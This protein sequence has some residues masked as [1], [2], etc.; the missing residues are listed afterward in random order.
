MQ[1][2]RP[3]VF[4]KQPLMH[5]Q[6]AMAAMLRVWVCSGCW[7]QLCFTPATRQHSQQPRIM[8]LLLTG[9]LQAQ[10]QREAL[11]HQTSMRLLRRRTSDAADKLDAGDYEDLAALA[12]RLATQQEE[13]ERL[14]GQLNAANTKRAE[15]AKVGWLSLLLG[16]RAIGVAPAAKVV[17]SRPVWVVL[18]PMYTK[19]RRL[20]CRPRL[21]ASG[22][23]DSSC[24][25]GAKP[26]PHWSTH[27]LLDHIRH[28]Q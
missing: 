2:T 26:Y 18:G 14:T 11:R 22:L 23:A 20:V 7:L 27:H 19:L 3:G 6:D 15:L 1:V 25:A 28:L 8:P 17:A 9:V 4:A 12:G 21:S 16:G 24:I 5:L 10:V 13:L